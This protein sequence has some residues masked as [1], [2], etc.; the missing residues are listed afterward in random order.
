[1]EEQG[2]SLLVH[3]NSIHQS[4]LSLSSSYQLQGCSLSSESQTYLS[5]ANSSETNGE[6]RETM[7]HDQPALS[8]I[9]K[10]GKIVS[11]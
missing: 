9:L 4:I 3:E 10:I 8:K 11:N 2:F 6:I 1:M 5:S 7:S